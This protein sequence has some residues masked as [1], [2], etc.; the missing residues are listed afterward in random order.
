MDESGGT[1]MSVIEVQQPRDQSRR[2]FCSHACHAAT[3]VALGSLLPACGGNPTGSS[4]GNAPALSTVNGTLSGGRVSVTVDAT[5][6]LNSVGGA[7]LIRASGSSYL[8]SR[9]SQDAF[10]VLTAT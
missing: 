7:A 9:T 4:G 2:E 8:A 10:V 1:L 6:P 3:L 5:S